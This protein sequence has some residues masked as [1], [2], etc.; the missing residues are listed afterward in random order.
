MMAG[1]IDLVEILFDNLNY[2]KQ[3]KGKNVHKLCQAFQELGQI[4]E[5]LQSKVDMIESFA[6]AY[7]FCEKSPGNGYRS[8]VNVVQ[9]AV[10]HAKKICILVQKNRD[11]LVFRKSFYEK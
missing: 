5:N 6:P 2:Y 1:D 11:S 9:A 8:F 10:V 4:V 3:V 7:D